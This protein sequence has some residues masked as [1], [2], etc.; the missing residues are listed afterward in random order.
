MK[1][2]YKN[3]SVYKYTN[4]NSKKNI[5]ISDIQF[6]S[7]LSYRKQNFHNKHVC[8]VVLIRLKSR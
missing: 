8:P 6:V 2:I 4:N 7:R 1:M 5:Y 3:T